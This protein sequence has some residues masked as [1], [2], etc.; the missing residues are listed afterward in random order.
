MLNKIRITMVELWKKQ[1]E[2][3]IVMVV[4]INNRPDENYNRWKI[5]GIFH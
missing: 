4:D 3:K 5:K 1:T 2:H